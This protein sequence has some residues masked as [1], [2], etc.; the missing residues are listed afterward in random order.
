MSDIIYSMRRRELRYLTSSFGI[1]YSV[2]VL[3]EGFL[4]IQS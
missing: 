4:Y 1:R 3:A 2:I